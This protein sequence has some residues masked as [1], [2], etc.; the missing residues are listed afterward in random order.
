MKLF[1]PWKEL[2]GNEY[3]FT[4]PDADSIP[5]LHGDIVDPQLVIFF[6]GNQFMVTH[7]LIDA[8]QRIYPQYQRIYWETL[9]PGV[10]VR[11]IENGG[12]RIGNLRIAHRPDIFTAGAARIRQLQEESDWFDRV[13]PYARNRL[14]IMVRAG[15][16]CLIDGL[17]DLGKP[18]VRISM[19][20]PR[21]EGIGRLMVEAYRK[22]GGQ[23]LVD[24]VMREKVKNGET[25]L[26]EIH[27][28]QTPL[29]IMQGLSDAGPV[30]ITEVLFQQQIGNPLTLVEIP[31]AY[32][33]VAIYTAARLKNAP[34]PQAA[35]AFLDFLTDPKGQEVYRKYGFLPL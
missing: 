1:P 12:L 32:N 24:L 11:Q 13:E 2:P 8:F 29:R 33:Q 16:P 28:R 3:H 23:A 17:T 9:P 20:D 5:D 25:F 15:N 34:H 31:P 26:T 18:G 22:A 7:D 27:H 4:V 30:W 21:S 14:G 19:P 10:L 6:H 35:D